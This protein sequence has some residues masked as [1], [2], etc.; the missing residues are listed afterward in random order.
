MR[1]TVA[2][3][4]A[5]SSRAWSRK[6]LWYSLLYD[7]YEYGL[8]GLNPYS[9]GDP[10]GKKRYSEGQNRHHRNYDS[11]LQSSAVRL[12]NRINSEVFPDGQHWAVFRPGDMWDEATSQDIQQAL[13]MV[14]DK[15]FRQIHLS[16]FSTAIN[17]MLLDGVVAGTG[18]MTVF[19][20]ERRGR[21]L[22]I[23]AV[24]QAEVAFEDGKGGETWGMYRKYEIPREH[25]KAYWP[26]AKIPPDTRRRWKDEKQDQ[27]ENESPPVETLVEATYYDPEKDIWY[28]DVILTTESSGESKERIVEREYDVCPWIVWSWM[29]ASGERQGRSPTMVALAD[30]KSLNKTKELLLKNASVSL[31]G[32]WIYQS[33]S[34]VN[35][36]TLAIRPG[37][38]IA[39][40]SVDKPR[41]IERL[42][43]GSE[44]H[45][46]QFIFQDLRMAIKESMLDRDLPPDAG[47]VRSA[48][49]IVERLKQLQQDLGAPFSR[50]VREISTPFLQRVVEVLS[51]KGQLPRISNGK[52]SR[53]MRLDGEE[54][55]IEFNSALAM[56]QK[57]LEVRNIVQWA[58]L[59]SVA[60]TEA[61]QMGIRI[62]N[63]PEKL[64]MLMNVPM[65][66]IRPE[67]ERKQGVAAMMQLMQQG[68][69]P[70]NDQAAPMKEAA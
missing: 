60:G 44:L 57:L 41:S 61:M 46:A 62:E 27:E 28:Y 10:Q 23:E 15:T 50:I 25:I 26:R 34:V 35:P 37:K 6:R 47:P 17:E 21:L 56:A 43:V 11:T 49:E 55:A 69:V 64:G 12:A 52:S 13:Q 38:F 14:E 32:V 45:L 70:G 66:L 58:E 42:D 59:S 63:V 4:L 30:A 67:A 9:E 24:C 54:V 3:V 19:G 2:A 51:Q 65:D 22:D 40:R 39:V 31:S 29:K 16:N 8:T 18:C 36:N 5:R 1:R 7:C 53:S 20:S 33:S 68:I 48:T